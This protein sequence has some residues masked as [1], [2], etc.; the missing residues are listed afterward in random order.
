MLRVALG[1]EA[2]TDMGGVGGGAGDALKSKTIETLH[3]NTLIAQTLI[4]KA[5]EK[6]AA[7]QGMGTNFVDASVNQT[8]DARQNNATYQNTPLDNPNKMIGALNS[9]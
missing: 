3:V 9:F 8:T 2:A 1:M 6:G 7:G 4:N 5:L